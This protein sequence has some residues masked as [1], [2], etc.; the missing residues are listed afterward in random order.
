[1][2]QQRDVTNGLLRALASGLRTHG[3]DV[4]LITSSPAPALSPQQLHRGQEMLHKRLE[5]LWSLGADTAV[6][7]VLMCGGQVRPHTLSALALP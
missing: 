1:M 3:L 6:C 4:S 2:W 5:P 7:V